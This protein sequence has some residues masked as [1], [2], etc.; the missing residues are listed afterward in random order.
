MPVHLQ[1]SLGLRVL[2]SGDEQLHRDK[3]EREGVRA[4][5]EVRERAACL[6]GEEAIQV[7]LGRIGARDVGAP[8]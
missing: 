6:E 1:D 8:Y 3:I 5:E 4:E 7:A 2:R